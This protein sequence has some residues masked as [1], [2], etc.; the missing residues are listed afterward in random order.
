ML[1][2]AP[3]STIGVLAADRQLLDQAQRHG[4]FGLRPA[5]LVTAA[6]A[7][8]RSQCPPTPSTGAPAA[9][10]GWDVTHACPSRATRRRGRGHDG[11]DDAD[12]SGDPDRG[13]CSRSSRADHDGVFR[14]D[15]DRAVVLDVHD[16]TAQSSGRRAGRRGCWS[17][18]RHP[19]S[20]SSTSTS[21]RARYPSVQR[22]SLAP[23]IDPGALAPRRRRARLAA[24][25]PCRTCGGLVSR[26]PDYL[27]MCGS[28]I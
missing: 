16:A 23:S 22:T 4:R 20:G 11:A 26:D 3:T 8:E 18:G 14:D 13:P 27:I 24:S 17:P 9:G 21:M 1:S 28:G 2:P 25:S 10:G 19:G 6:G 15:L 7:V 12:V 5:E